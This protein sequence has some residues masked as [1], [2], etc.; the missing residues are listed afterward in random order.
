M[1]YYNEFDP[2][3][4]AWIQGLIDENLIPPGHVDT[5]SITEISPQDLDGYTQCHF[6]AGIGGWPL[7]FQL[8][9]VPSTRSLWTGSC[10]CQPFSVAGE[11]RGIED[12]RHLWPVFFDLIRD[13]NPPP[14]S[15]ENKSPARQSSDHLQSR[16]NEVLEKRFSQS[17][18]MEY[19]LTSKVHHTP[20]GRRIFR[21]RAS[22]H[23]ISVNASGGEP[24]G[25]P[26]P[27][28]RG[29]KD[30]PGMATTG[31]NPDGSERTRLDQLARVANLVG[32]SPVGT[33]AETANTEGFQLNLAFSLWLMGYPT[34]WHDAGLSALRSFVEQA[35]PLSRKSGRN[36]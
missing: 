12:E 33:I 18:S 29:W 23:R 25:W 14:S 21:L 30:T 7:A 8:A 35:M 16:L 17:G 10:P 32:G 31:T 5:R 20:A 28:S 11:G 2:H 6:F 24:S 34:K 15:S 9:G 4:A 1:N 13:C 27:S 22:A 3:A 26:T 19:S 36:S